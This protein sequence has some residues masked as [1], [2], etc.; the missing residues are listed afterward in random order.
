MLDRYCHSLP[1]YIS[2]P[3][4]SSC[5]FRLSCPPLPFHPPVPFRSLSPPILSRSPDRK[6][7]SARRCRPGWQMSRDYAAS[8]FESSAV[9]SGY[10]THAFGHRARRAINIYAII[11]IYLYAATKVAFLLSPSLRNSGRSI[12]TIKNVSLLSINRYYQRSVGC[13]PVW[14]QRRGENTYE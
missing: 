12:W 14:Q 8:R 9:T 6:M 11:I 1:E 3:Y 4:T 2:K 10:Y 5:L 7:T 13:L